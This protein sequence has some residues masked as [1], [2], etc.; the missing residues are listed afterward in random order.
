MDDPAKI[1]GAQMA[2]SNQ[3]LQRDR[4]IKRLEDQIKQA[5]T[6]LRKCIEQRDKARTE[7][8]ANRYLLTSI[9]DHWSFFFLPG[10]LKNS[11][12]GKLEVIYPTR[13]SVSFAHVS[14]VKAQP[15]RRS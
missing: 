11:I 8:G 4:H 6:L 14:K 15:T 2:E 5:Q 7:A 10:W 3:A 9:A 13:A 1:M 12:N